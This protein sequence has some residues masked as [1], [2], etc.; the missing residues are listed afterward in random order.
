MITKEMKQDIINTYGKD[1]ND[2]GSVEVQVALLTARIKDSMARGNIDGRQEDCL[3]ASLTGS[4]YHDVAV[5]LK[6]FAIQV[7]MGIN[8][9]HYLSRWRSSSM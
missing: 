3:T 2:T 8:E 1:S 9:I 4:L 5:V 7:A 6:F